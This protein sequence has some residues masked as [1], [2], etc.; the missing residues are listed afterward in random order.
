MIADHARHLH[1]SQ[2]AENVRT[3]ASGDDDAWIQARQ[4]DEQT[5]GLVAHDGLAWML[6]NGRERPVEIECAQRAL[7]GQP[8]QNRTGSPGKKVMHRQTAGP[9]LERSASLPATR[10]EEHTSELQSLRHLVCRLL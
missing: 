7:L 3:P 2:P 1:A 6:H 9:P 10:S 5:P 4:A 8:H